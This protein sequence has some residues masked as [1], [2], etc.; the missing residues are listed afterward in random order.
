MK[1]EFIVWTLEAKKKNNYPEDLPDFTIEENHKKVSTQSWG[2]TQLHDVFI[3]T[4]KDIVFF[5]FT[6][7]SITEDIVKNIWRPKKDVISF[8]IFFKVQS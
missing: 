5:F 7:Q 6:P 1:S 2:V 3:F 4:F 8:E